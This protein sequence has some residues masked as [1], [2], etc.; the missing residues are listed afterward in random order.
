MR[1]SSTPTEGHFPA[2][3]SANK[4]YIAQI[5]HYYRW[6]GTI[7]VPIG[8]PGGIALGETSATAY[9]GDRGKAAY[10][11]SLS[12]HAPATAQKNSDITKGEI[13][14]KLTG[15][16]SSHTHS[17]GVPSPHASTHISGGADTIPNATSTNSGLLSAADKAKLDGIASEANKY[18]HPSSDGYHH[19]PA[20]GTSNNQKVLKSGATAGSEHWG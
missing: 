16:I 18:I 9:R 11:H 15:V 2:T 14:A 13:E 7:Y 3:G 17:S 8:T 1:L 5:Q 19:V 20:T 6:G 12:S 10:D 4:I